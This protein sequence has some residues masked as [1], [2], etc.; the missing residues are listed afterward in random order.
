ML[1]LP[2]VDDIHAAVARL[3]GHAVRTPLLR[4]HVLDERVGGRVFLKAENLQRT[5]SFKFRGAFNAVTAYGERARAG[6]VACSSGNHAQGVA[7]AA[8]IHG[9]PATIV[10]PSDAPRAK[11]DR[12]RRLGATVVEYERF[13]EDRTAIARAIAERDGAVFIHPYEDPYVI[14]GQGTCGLEMAEQ[15]CEADAEPHAVLVCAGGGGLSAGV[16]LALRAAFRDVAVH[17]VEPENFD[18]QRRSLDAGER[19]AIEPG[20]ASICDAI[21]TDSPGERAFAILRNHATGLT[22]SDGEALQAVAFAFDEL[23]LVVEPGGAVALA[24]ILAGR[25]ETRGRTLVATLSGGNIDPAV[26]RRA[27]DG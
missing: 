19:V 21:V 8:A 4:S 17:L 7:A 10:M 9:V 25:V 24:A 11:M 23:K 20:H 22:V 18:D 2:T 5:G 16:S 3:D 12:T 6:V 15:L 1:D 14:A 13:V 26:L 27:L